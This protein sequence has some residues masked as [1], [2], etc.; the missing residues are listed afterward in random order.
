MHLDLQSEPL[1]VVK[2]CQKFQ[3][4]T[5]EQLEEKPAFEIVSW[6]L[7]LKSLLSLLC[8]SNSERILSTFVISSLPV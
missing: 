8:L 3:C 5:A 2:V 1:P 6:A 7:L 4:K